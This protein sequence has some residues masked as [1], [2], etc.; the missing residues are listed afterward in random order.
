MDP[1]SVKIEVL[2]QEMNMIEAIEKSDEEKMKSLRERYKKHKS[3][4]GK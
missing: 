3:K 1:S 4:L 2:S